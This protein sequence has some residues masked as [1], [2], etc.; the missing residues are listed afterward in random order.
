MK[1]ER[2]RARIQHMFQI[3]APNIQLYLP[4]QSHRYMHACFQQLLSAFLALRIVVIGR[5]VPHAVDT[6]QC[7]FTSLLNHFYSL[8]T[9]P[10]H[11]SVATCVS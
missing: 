5:S 6:A 7:I 9:L 4:Y 2:Q 8:D 3:L 10:H 11:N 1:R